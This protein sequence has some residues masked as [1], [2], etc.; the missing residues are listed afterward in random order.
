MVHVD[1][2]K[3][4]IVQEKPNN[5]AIRCLLALHKTVQGKQFWKS[6]GKPKTKKEKNQTE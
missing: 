3:G 6:K 1:K 2:N 4:Y 5:Y